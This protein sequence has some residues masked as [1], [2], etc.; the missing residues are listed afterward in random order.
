MAIQEL[1]SSRNNKINA[2]EFVGQQDR[3][4]YD[5]ETQT[6]RVSDGITPGGIIINSGG[7]GGGGVGPRGPTGPTGARGA[8][9]PQ[10]DTGAQ[11]TR[12]VTG[13]TGP[14]GIQGMLGPTG[15]AGVAGSAVYE[16]ETPPMDA[17]NGNFWYDPVRL[18]LYFRYNDTWVMVA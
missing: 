8:T 13:P 3:L 14:T 5:I 1:F 7:S 12:G 11:G 9:G 15:P 4:F 18:E 6:L 10:G 2:N 17:T 16:G